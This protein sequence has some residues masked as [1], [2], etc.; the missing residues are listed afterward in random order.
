MSDM[1]VSLNEYF[2]FLVFFS[3]GD[4]L[5][6]EVAVIRDVFMRISV[7]KCHF[8]LSKV[9]RLVLKSLVNRF[10]QKEKNI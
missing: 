1:L 5:C 10:L 4:G 7:A 9:Q 6:N 2:H 3:D 8:L